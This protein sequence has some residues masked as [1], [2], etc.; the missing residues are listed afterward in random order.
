MAAVFPRL[1]P[2]Q[3]QEGT[4][5]KDMWRRPILSYQQYR[6]FLIQAVTPTFSEMLP[7]PQKKKEERKKKGKH[8]Q[9]NSH[10]QMIKEREG[11]SLDRNS[12]LSS[13]LCWRSVVLYLPD[14]V[15]GVTVDSCN[16][17]P[18]CDRQ[19]PND[20]PFRR[21]WL[22]LVVMMTCLHSSRALPAPHATKSMPTKWWMR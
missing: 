15:V 6:W 1:N 20:Q 8:L 10:K 14:V 12:N 22:T 2:F 19:G 4:M 18:I 21:C 17:W 16:M 11:M 13:C 5:T 9:V 7:P 3:V